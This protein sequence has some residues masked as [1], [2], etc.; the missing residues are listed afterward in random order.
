MSGVLP[1]CECGCGSNVEW[2]D[3]KYRFNTFLTGHNKSGF[4][5]KQP[6]FSK[7]Q[8][9]NRNEKIK[10]T[11]VNRGDE[12][13]KKISDSVKKGLSESNIDF[14]SYFN[15]KWKNDETF[16]K[17]QTIARIKSWEGDAGQIRRE[18]VF[19][20]EF[21]K[22]ISLANMNRDANRVSKAETRFADHLRSIG[23]NVQTSKWF[24][25]ESKSWCADI[26]LPD[27]N[28]IV[29]FDGTFWHGNDRKENFTRC[30]LSNMTNDIIKNKIAK[31]KKLNL[32]RI[33]ESIDIQKICTYDNLLEFAS[34]HVNDGVVI[35]EGTRLFNDNDVLMSRND[36][37]RA[38]IEDKLETKM[39]TLPVIIDFL[40]A[41]VDYHGWFYPQCDHKLSY[42]I[43]RLKQTCGTMSK[44]SY[45]S[46]WLKSRL[47]SFW[48]VEPG[49]SK[50]F[51][52]EKII[53][54]V[55][56][57]RLGLN[58][59]KMYT[60]Y[61]D[62]EKIT[63]N[64]TFDITLKTIRTGFIVQRNKVS[65]FKPSW[66][67]HIYS[68]FIDNSI[69]SPVVWDPSIGFSARML[70]FSAL[71]DSGY[72]IG[73]DPAKLTFN[74]AVQISNE[75]SALKH[76]LK[77]E[78]INVGSECELG[79]KDESVD[80][81]FTSPPYFDTEKYFN[82]DGQ[83]WKDFS[84]YDLWLKKY[85]MKTFMNAYSC[86]KNKSKM[87]INISKKYE[88][89]VILVATNC[90]FKYRHEQNVVLDICKDHFSRSNNTTGLKQENFLVFEKS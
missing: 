70:G 57:Y 73:T 79:I 44:S 82:E 64:E 59:S 55:C 37:I 69:S 28:M 9:A 72:Y 80:L 51:H 60:Y 67:S 13:K 12:I 18:K 83:C 54:S 76:N 41:H 81:V 68:K 56:S 2:H 43:D 45:G 20:P 53:N 31:D 10:Q 33:D 14:S 87:I 86:L 39:K 46:S 35:R 85:L 22:K 63:C 4:R 61:V 17:N 74:D 25:F 84:S 24:N 36:I 71:Y 26:W 34:H 49:A 62:G 58:N 32:I 3:S 15:N 42:E 6:I 16:I 5:E 52:N 75:I 48:D 88:N 27:H 90:G 1:L 23:L 30:Q 38:N 47:R 29:E 65:W 40:S 11:Y 77:F 7:E 78:L 21:G 66:A 89:D 19:T 50:Q 8:I